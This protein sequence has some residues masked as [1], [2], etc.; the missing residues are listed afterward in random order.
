MQKY[1][2]YSLFV[3]VALLEGTWY[4]TGI[5]CKGVTISP[6]RWYKRAC[7]AGPIHLF[8]TCLS[9][10]SS[11][12]SDFNVLRNIWM[13]FTLSS[14]VVPPHHH[15][16]Q[17]STWSVSPGCFVNHQGFWGI[18]SI[19]QNQT[20]PF[21]S[22]VCLCVCVVWRITLHSPTCWRGVTRAEEEPNKV[23]GRSIQHI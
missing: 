8:N 15:H 12:Y 1:K 4:I 22:V 14:S 3:F 16:H 20:L 17:R 7:K 11:L 21:T 5:F 23:W 19:L 13:L 6:A 9:H 10:T 18:K 2:C